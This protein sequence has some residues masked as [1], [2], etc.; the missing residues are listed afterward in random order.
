MWLSNELGRTVKVRADQPVRR[1]A[2]ASALMVG[3]LTF[4]T[5]VLAGAASAPAAQAVDSTAATVTAAQ[6]DPDAAGS[7]FPALSVTVS[8]TTDLTGQGIRLNYSG[9]MKSTV[10][11]QQTAGANFLQVFQCWGDLK[12][13]DGKLVLDAS[14]EAQPDRTTCQYGSTGQPGQSRNASK[15]SLDAV[16]PEDEPY[17]YPGS[18]PFDPPQVS[19]PFKAVNGKLLQRVADGKVVSD[20]DLDNNEFFTKNTTNEVPWIGFG[21]SGEGTATFEVQTNSQ[22]PGLGCGNP[23]TA[24]DGTVSGQ[25]C[26]V[27]IVPRGDHDLGEQAVTKSAL[28]WETWKH[29]LAVKLQFKPLGVRCAIG[30][31]EKSLAGS[32]LMT[33]AVASWQPRLCGTAGGSVFNLIFANEADQAL[34][35]NGTDT[36]AL[37]L[38][39]RAL[40]IDGV[41]D[42]LTYA[43]VGISGLAVGFAIDHLA[44]P[45]RNDIPTSVSDLDRQ[46]FTTMNLTPRL[47]AKLLTD[48]YKASMPTGA[49]VS[50]LKSNPYYL[51]QDPDF[52]AVN[53]D[54]WRYQNL[55]SPSHLADLLVPLGRSD[56]AW[57]VWQYVLADPEAVS[58][59]AGARDPWGMVVNAYSATSAT[60]NPTGT[61]ATYPKDSFPKADPTSYTPDGMG[62]INLVTWRPYAT[63]LDTAAYWTLRGDNRSL[64]QSSWDVIDPQPKYSLFSRDLAGSQRVLGLTDTA[65][66]AKYQVFTA[67]LRN[68]AGTFVQPT[69]AS[70][71]AAAAV[72]TPTVGQPQVS[73]LDYTSAAV[74]QARD[75]YPLAVPIYAA[76][77]AAGGEATVRA[78]YAAF[79]KYAVGAGQIPGTDDGELPVG[80]APLPASWVAAARQAADTIAAGPTPTPAAA[81]ATSTVGAVEVSRAAGSTADV[82][83][84]PAAS[85]PVPAIS[86]K[87]PT[88]SGPAAGPVVGHA[89]PG[90]PDVGA[91]RAAVPIGAAGGLLAAAGVP[92]VSRL[93][94]RP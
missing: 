86:S 12:D 14:G 35:A 7:P 60:A 39:T 28:L 76:T 84:A 80:Y 49:D 58:F 3:L 27:V 78:A 74:K 33:A 94:R 75:A 72:M 25:P 70:M 41:T 18:G 65:S 62:E 54:A 9:G 69:S 89:T 48:S 22:A 55:S 24:G 43:P 50:H 11:N 44:D 61:A 71:A 67:A 91:L 21:A 15:S 34:E 13:A 45:L 6:Q 63:D 26:W 10:P 73:A 37:A 40:S 5:V 1:G 81:P 52:L 47:V 90:D 16:S 88:A 36:A 59:L 82:A 93:R 77:N 68:A 56:A 83:Q 8:Q 66:A 53:D 92:L 57:V 85:S 20:V 19:V 32:E 79:I 64:N 29:R 87:S 30:A 4:S 23:I 42:H 46:P 2:T 31:A 51:W 38:T 17:L